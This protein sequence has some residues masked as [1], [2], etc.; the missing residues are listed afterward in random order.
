MSLD[1][2]KVHHWFT[3]E[4][5]FDSLEFILNYLHYRFCR[6]CPRGR[7]HKIYIYMKL[8]HHNLLS[9]LGRLPPNFNLVL[10]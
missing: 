7:C 1:S 8:T 10:S 6:S 4:I 9:F 2:I 5:I 3:T